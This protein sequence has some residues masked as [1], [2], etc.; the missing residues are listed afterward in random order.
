MMFT[1]RSVPSGVIIPL[2]LFAAAFTSIVWAADI[3]PAQEQQFRDAK[4]ALA[5]AH[6]AG[7]DKLAT[8]HLKQ[9]ES[10]LQTAENARQIQDATG[11]T[12]ASLLA[13]AYAE[14]AE[15]LAEL[16]ADNA[17][18]AETQEALRKAKADIEQLKS[19]P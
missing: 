14:L 12:R 5:T 19:R 13:R 17:K 15:A 1:K 7:A 3:G 11:F 6:S 10:F 18:L 9:A 8:T 2:L 4:E 16:E